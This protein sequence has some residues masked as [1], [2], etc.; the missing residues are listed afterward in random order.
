MQMRE[1][2]DESNTA[3]FELWTPFVR[4][5]PGG[6]ARLK[7]LLALSKLNFRLPKIDAF[8]SSGCATYCPSL[9]QRQTRRMYGGECFGYSNGI[10]SACTV[11]PFCKI[12]F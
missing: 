7:M 12:A 1:T 10:T 5:E 2:I 8:P 11:K 3:P 9:C 6:Q 4:D